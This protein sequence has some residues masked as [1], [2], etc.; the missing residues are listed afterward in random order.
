VVR[1]TAH[2]LDK[3]VQV[4]RVGEEVS[5]DKLVV[6]GMLD[7]L[8]HIARNAVDHG[9]ED[10]VS[11][12][13][14]GKAPVGRISISAENTAG[15]VTIVFSDDGRGIDG[16]KV[17][18]KA[19]ERGLIERDR[20]LSAEEKLELIFLPG[21]STASAVTEVSGRGVG[22]DVV[23]DTVKRMGG[24]VEIQSVQGQGTTMTITLPTNISIIDALIVKIG[25]AQYALPNQDLMEVVNLTDFNVQPV[26]GGESQVIDLRGSVVAVEEMAAF[27]DGGASPTKA[28]DGTRPAILVSYR[29]QMLA[30]AVESVV[31][32]QQIFVRP[33]IG[34]LAPIG[35]YGG[36]TILSDGEPTI[37]LN[38]PEMAR[39]FF[40]SH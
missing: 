22:M 9:V 35:F 10:V 21:L 16:D 18:A 8:I 6:D 36:S 7:P 11:R 20:D 39:R 17:Y 14:A 32:Q 29:D 27:L 2:Q 40:T 23:N 30:L 31:G 26:N 15:G 24:R 25:G 13:Q 1:E 28:S 5:L 3:Q 4:E 37:I 19:I 12:V 38:L 34:H 33:M